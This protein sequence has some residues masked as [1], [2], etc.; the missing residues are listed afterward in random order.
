MAHAGES[1]QGVPH[2]MMP[3]LHSATINTRCCDDSLDLGC[4]WLPL[5]SLCMTEVSPLRLCGFVKMQLRR[6][7][8]CTHSHQINKH[9][10]DDYYVRTTQQSAGP[11]SA[12]WA[13][14][15]MRLHTQRCPL[16]RKIVCFVCASL[17][18]H[19]AAPTRI[20]LMARLRCL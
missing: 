12:H 1:H 16:Y 10:R 11:H 4:Q 17:L 20:L 19:V 3:M 14:L 5:Y 9:S 15:P 18:R 13:T 7:C 6:Q 2:M 8:L